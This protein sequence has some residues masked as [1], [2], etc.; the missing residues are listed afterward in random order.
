MRLLSVWEAVVAVLP[1]V[2]FPVL[3]HSVVVM[4]VTA[5]PVP[6]SGVI[7]SLREECLR[8]PVPVS[9]PAERAVPV[10]PVVVSVSVISPVPVVV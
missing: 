2:T 3:S 1:P 4:V 7:A 6:L 8:L 10:R 9:V 5:V